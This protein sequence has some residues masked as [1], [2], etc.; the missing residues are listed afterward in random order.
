MAQATEHSI[1]A[2]IIQAEI[3]KSESLIITDS[4]GNPVVQLRA[5]AENTIQIMDKYGNIC[6]EIHIG[7]TPGK[8]I[9]SI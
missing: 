6:T 7:Q 4:N 3:I 8:H 1:K 9:K 2:D 5:G